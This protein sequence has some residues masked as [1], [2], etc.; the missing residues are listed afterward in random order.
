MKLID[1]MK[2]IYGHEEKGN[3]LFYNSL[4]SYLKWCKWTTSALEAPNP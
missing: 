3:K 4:P 2:T 1:I